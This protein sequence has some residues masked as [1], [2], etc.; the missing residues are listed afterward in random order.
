MKQCGVGDT[1]Y[2]P[3]MS[4]CLEFDIYIY[5]QKTL[6]DLFFPVVSHDLFVQIYRMCFFNCKNHIST[7]WKIWE[8]TKPKSLYIL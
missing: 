4:V 1:K 3:F 2:T 7:I 5:M 6:R 8:S